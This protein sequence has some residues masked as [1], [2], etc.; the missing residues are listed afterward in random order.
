M[1]WL[2][3]RADDLPGEAGAVVEAADH[4]ATVTLTLPEHDAVVG[5][6]VL[7][8]LDLETAER[9]AR[10]L[11]GV[12]DVTVGGARGQIPRRV[13]LPEVL[14]LTEPDAAQI[15][16][17]WRERP[18][19]IDAPVGAGSVGTYQLDMRADGPHALVGGTTGAGKSEFLQTFVVALGMATRAQPRP[20]DV[21][22]RR[23]QGRRRVHRAPSTCRT[24][25]AS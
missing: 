18:L 15:L 4:P 12:K 5:P 8:R 2:G 20:P 22:A 16:H 3:R 24:P 11:S 10:A 23:L 7:D 1:I 14:G 25:S 13:S 21:P 6:G 19:G 17:R 9:V